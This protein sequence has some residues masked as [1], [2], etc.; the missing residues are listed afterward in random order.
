LNHGY[1]VASYDV[2]HEV[3]VASNAH[4]AFVR[5]REYG[6]AVAFEKYVEAFMLVADDSSVGKD[7]GV[8]NL[9]FGLSKSLAPNKDI[10]AVWCKLFP[11]YRTSISMTVKYT[12]ER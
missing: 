7:E 8:V 12:N 2:G 6:G 3:G 1:F 4:L 5:T 11:V 9:S 10:T